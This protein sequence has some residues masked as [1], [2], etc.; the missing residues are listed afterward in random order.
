GSLAEVCGN[1]SLAGRRVG[2]K[3]TQGRHD[4]ARLVQVCRQ[5]RAFGKKRIAICIVSGGDIKWRAGISDDKSVH[6]KPRTRLIAGP[7]IEPMSDVERG[8]A[9]FLTEVVR[10]KSRTTRPA[11]AAPIFIPGIP[12]PEINFVNVAVQ[13]NFDRFV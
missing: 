11:V 3:S 12:T 1:D 4:H 13:F 6:A 7:G 10:I 9:P 2:I 8:A 5:G